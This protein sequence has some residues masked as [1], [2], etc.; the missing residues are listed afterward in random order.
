MPTKMKE[1]DPN[2]HEKHIVLGNCAIFL[3][4]NQKI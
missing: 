4:W 3:L 2:L 1:E